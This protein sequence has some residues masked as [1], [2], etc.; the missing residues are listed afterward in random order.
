LVAETPDN[1]G[2]LFLYHNQ[3]I[4]RHLFA[5]DQAPH[6]RNQSLANAAASAPTRG[7]LSRPSQRE[8]GYPA[9]PFFSLHAEQSMK[10]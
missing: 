10:K 8:N 7:D 4:Y 5:G 9:I 1:A 2:G 6:N 3:I